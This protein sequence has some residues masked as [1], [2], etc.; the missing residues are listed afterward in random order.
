MTLIE[1]RNTRPGGPNRQERAHRGGAPEPLTE[2]IKEIGMLQVQTCVSVHCVQCGDA[3]GDPGFEAHYPTEDAAL[4][5]AAAQGWRVGP[6]GRLWCSA[7]GPVMTCEAQ[8]H[9]FTQWHL[10]PVDEHH[11]PLPHP[12]QAAATAKERP[13]G[14]E[15]RSCRRCCLHESRPAKW[16][17]SEVSGRGKSVALPFELLAAG[18]DVVGEVA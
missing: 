10:L 4:D 14:R 16:L 9:E 17:I 6:G 8:V 15:Y 1:M 12:D 5:A 18:T 3:L 7:C 13:A 11:G 2:A